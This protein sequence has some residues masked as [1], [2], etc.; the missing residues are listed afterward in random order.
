MGLYTLRTM[1]EPTWQM[2]MRA[3]LT[4]RKP[5]R[6]DRRTPIMHVIDLTNADRQ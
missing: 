3:I 2:S 4:E 5:G 1:T 6:S